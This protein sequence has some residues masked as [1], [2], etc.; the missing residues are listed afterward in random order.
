MAAARAYNMLDDPTVL[1]AARWQD[2]L[3]PRGMDGRF[4]EKF[5]MV[6]VFGKPG[7]ERTL[8]DPKANR[9]RAR[10][11][12]LFPEGATVEYFDTQGNPAPADSGNGYP[13][14]IK[15]D[16]I[17]KKISSAP[18]SKARL[19]GVS[20]QEEFE[21]G[22]REAMS[23]ADYDAAVDKFNQRV[24]AEFKP[25]RSAAHKDSPELTDDEFSEHLDYVTE[26]VDAGLAKQPDGTSGLASESAFK[27]TYGRWSQEQLERMLTMADDLYGQV[28]DGRVKGHK[29]IVLGGLPGS[30]KSTLLADL[31][32]AG[33]IQRDQW[34]EINPDL[35][36]DE[37]IARG[38]YPQIQG[39][40]PNETATFIHAQSSE[41]ASMLERMAMKDGYNLIFD[42]TMGSGGING[43]TWTD[44]TVK[45]LMF[46]GYDKPD[47][48]FIDSDINHSLASVAYRH[49]D[50]LN[51]Y[52][53]G[54]PTH[55]RRPGPEINNGGRFVPAQAVAETVGT[56]V[57]TSVNVQNFER[58]KSKFDRW[59]QYEVGGVPG[60]KPAPVLT[61]STPQMPGYPGDSF[62]GV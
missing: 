37:M 8:A 7:G 26:V 32:K 43:E 13:A 3:H 62:G 30:G 53:T 59:A 45:Q 18:N 61:D 22:H 27:D 31:D 23:Q 20:S 47:G 12:D 16:E 11:T 24:D 38:W 17:S 46:Y 52:R 21:A 50:G 48:M 6:D 19:Q 29:A 35:V 40:T 49:R 9:R 36:K 58:L 5:S 54:A 33:T 39:L 57:A 34:V 14:Y 10:I 55:D 41:M 42:T 51:Q 1:T 4:I 44:H 60:T 28:T 15:L 25:E 56:D 2:W